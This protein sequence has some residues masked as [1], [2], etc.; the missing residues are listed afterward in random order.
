VSPRVN[1]HTPFQSLVTTD[2]LLA[3]L[4]LTLLP[5]IVAI[6][7]G[8]ATMSAYLRGGGADAH[9]AAALSVAIL[10]GMGAQLQRH[11]RVVD[12]HRRAT[13]HTAPRFCCPDR[14]RTMFDRV[15]QLRRRDRSRVGERRRDAGRDRAGAPCMTSSDEHRR[16]QQSSGMTTSGR[17]PENVR[18]L[19]VTSSRRLAVCEAATRADASSG[20]R[21]TCSQDLECFVGVRVHTDLTV[22][23]RNEGSV[24]VDYERRALHLEEVRTPLDA[25]HRGDGAIDVGE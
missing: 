6:L 2:R 22:E 23:L 17:R 5:F 1:H 9:L 21:S 18:I 7:F 25:E 3:F 8:T 12:P 15:G 10:D 14:A 20:G 13:P 4:N 24:R 16:G 11:F 19:S